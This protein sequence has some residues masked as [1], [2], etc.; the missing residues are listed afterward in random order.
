MKKI[1]NILFAL[2]FLVILNVNA[3]IL[4]QPNPNYFHL[5]IPSIQ[6][7]TQKAN[8]TVWAYFGM[9]DKDHCATTIG[10]IRLGTFE[11]VTNGDG[12]YWA[13]MPITLK[14]TQPTCVVLK[15]YTTDHNFN[16]SETLSIVRF[17]KKPI[18]T[19]PLVT[20]ITIK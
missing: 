18:E 12:L 14:R 6:T 1:F 19:M 8:L 17:D 13:G 5:T 9:G 15:Y 3:E 20:Y 4:N 2:T 16:T 7:P 10:G 11:N